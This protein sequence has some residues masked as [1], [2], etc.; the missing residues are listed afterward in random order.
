MEDIFM[1]ISFMFNFVTGRLNCSYADEDKPTD[2]LSACKMEEE[3][4]CSMKY[5]HMLEEP[6][7]LLQIEWWKTWLKGLFKMRTLPRFTL[8]VSAE[9]LHK[10][11]AKRKLMDRSP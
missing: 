1:L 6:K 4:V 10:K 2:K 11:K 9:I 7:Y 8:W 5:E 3:I